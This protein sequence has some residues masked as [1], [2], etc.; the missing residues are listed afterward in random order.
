VGALAVLIVVL[1][2]FFIF[3]R[4]NNA[5]N[6][7]PAVQP[8]GSVQP[9]P[10]P[11]GFGD[12][13]PTGVASSQP[14]TAPVAPDAIAVGGYAVV[15]GTGDGLIVRS[16][17]GRSGSRIAKIADGTKARVVDGPQEADGFTWWKLDQFDKSNPA[18]TGWSV[19][20]YLKASAP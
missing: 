6:Q 11:T 19:Q 1:A 10:T 17:P 5:S 3:N 15:T 18:L 16:S 8:I 4:G 9:Q 2:A 12:P 14:T 20:D 7:N 13:T